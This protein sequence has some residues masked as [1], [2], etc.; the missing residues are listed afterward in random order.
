MNYLIYGEEQGKVKKEVDKIIKEVIHDDPYGCVSFNASAISFDEILN[1]AQTP[2]FFGD[3]KVV[4]IKNANFLSASNDT[5]VD[6]VKLEEYLNNPQGTTTLI[7]MGEFAK[8]DQ[9]K[10]IVKT[11]NKTCRVLV[12]NPM[13][14]R[15]KRTYLFNAINERM[16]KINNQAKERLIELL[17]N[18]TRIIDHEL[19]KCE[20]FPDELDVET[21]NLLISRNLDEDVFQLINAILHQ[22]MKKVFAIYQDLFVLNKETIYLIAVLASQF[23]FYLQ[24]KT[25]LVQGYSEAEI[26]SELRAHPYRV[27]LSIQAVGSNT[28]QQFLDVLDELATCD[29][30]IKNGLIDKKLGFE[31]LLLKT[32]SIFA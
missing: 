29:Q 6:T 22:D 24:V 30:K 20:N 4:L 11:V 23:R 12:C 18:D 32:K 14:E 15:D 1:E 25:L 26:T 28:C 13:D 31:L 7:M 8:C 17:P 27:K 10:K 3:K 5:E 16:I 19:D 2:P 9:R 21:I